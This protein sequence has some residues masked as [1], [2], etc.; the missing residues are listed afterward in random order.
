[1]RRTAGQYSTAYGIQGESALETEND[2]L[3]DELKG[4]INSLKM[5]SL[6]LGTDIKEQNSFLRQMDDDF[7]SAGSFLGSVSGRLKRLAKGS[8][9]RVWL[10]LFLFSLCVFS[11]LWLLLKFS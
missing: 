7:D 3:T 6:D 2:R 9:N 5:I 8:Q 1:M 10:Y 11:V 4:K